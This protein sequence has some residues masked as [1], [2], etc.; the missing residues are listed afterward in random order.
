MYKIKSFTDL[1]AW[2]EG[3]KLVLQIYRITKLFPSEERFCLIDQMRRCVISI[4]SNI[5]EGFSRR[6]KKEKAQFFYMALG[7]VTEL[8]NQLLIARDLNYISSAEFK[9]IADQTVVVSKLV[10]GL[11]KSS[12]ALNS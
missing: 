6:S 10:N 11:I 2:K 12:K 4:T 9:N 5:A 1:N 3:H 7:S 8:Q